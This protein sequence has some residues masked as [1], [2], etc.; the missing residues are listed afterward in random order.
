MKRTL[1]SFA[2]IFAFLSLKSQYNQGIKIEQLL[3]TDTTT[4]GQKII[5]PISDNDEVTILRITIEPGQS[6]G[7]HKHEIPVFAYVLKGSLTV[8]L[9]DNKTIVYQQNSSFSEVINTLHN[10]INK[11]N[12][13]VIL[14]AFFMGEKGKALSKHKE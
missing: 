4:T 10:G 7:W 2:L 13:N 9:E 14:I 3:K 11:G 12:E 5:Y 1:L 8:E 6:T